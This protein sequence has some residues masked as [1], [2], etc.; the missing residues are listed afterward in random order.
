MSGSPGPV[1]S[2]APGYGPGVVDSAFVVAGSV[3]SSAAVTTITDAVSVMAWVKPRS[4]QRVQTVVARSTGPGF[5]SA[6]DVSH[7]YALRIGFPWGVEWEVDDPSSLVPEVVRA[8]VFE[9]LDDGS[10][11]HLAASWEPGL[12][13]VYLDG[14]EVARHVSRSAAINAAGSTPFTI[15]GEHLSPFDFEGSIDEVMLF[16]RAI[17]TSEVAACVPPP[18]IIST[19]AGNGIFG[20]SGDG[21]AAVDAE[22][23][24]VAHVAA[25]RHGNVYI[26]DVPNSRIRKVSPGGIVTTVA[27]TGTP[28]FSGDGGPATNAQLDAPA[29][30]AIDASGNL[31]IADAG[32]SRIRMVSP[33]GIISTVAG[34]GV[35]GSSGDGGPASEAQFLSP[36]GL[37]IDTSGN[38]YV[39]DAHADRVRRVAADGTIATLAGIGTP[40]FSGDGGPATA[41]RLRFPY[42]VAVDE[43]GNVYIADT[44]NYRVRMVSRSGVISTIAGGGPGCELLPGGVFN[45]NARCP[46]VN[47]YLRPN[48]VAVDDRGY[49]YI[50][51]LAPG[52]NQVRRVSPF[53]TIS[54]FAGSGF[55]FA[56]DGGPALEARL[57]F[58][59]SV[60]VDGAGNVFIG[61]NGNLRVRKVAAQP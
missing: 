21:G 9:S 19:H 49:L 61:D 41:A 51:D 13:V 42:G 11:H 46:A 58:P 30:M 26:A 36:T 57:S 15:G 14:V 7:G 48:S 16:D 1:L 40:G 37:A 55:G 52:H 28:G 17:T 29:G 8:Q 60:A 22:F 38:L 35:R 33:T 31:F 27:G 6:S 3:M 23:G 54:A 43:A 56:G 59:S 25:D 18:P 5:S 47:A 44:D 45:A 12:M 50:N 4:L 2:G 53:G 20:F 39:A 32:N 24:G 34:T 10:W